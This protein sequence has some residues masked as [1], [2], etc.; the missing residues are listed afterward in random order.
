MPSTHTSLH[1]HCTFSTKDRFP[2]IDKSWRARL[3]EYIGGTIRG[4]EAKP[5]EVGGIADHVHILIGIRPAQCVADAIR[6]IKKASTS[7]IR[8]VIGCGSF[9]WQDGYGAFTVSRSDIRSVVE[10][11]RNQEE[12]HRKRSF[13]EEY[14][15]FLETNG[16]EYD[17]R[18]LW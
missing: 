18:Y 15:T 11:I 3:H 14:R 13:Q 2:F 5:L 7:W 4:L 9:H 8:D 12:H 6:E 10:Y 16:I 17:E 1:V